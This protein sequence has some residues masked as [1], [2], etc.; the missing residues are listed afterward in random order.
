MIRAWIGS[1][2]DTRRFCPADDADYD[3]HHNIS[4][5][6][7]DE[8]RESLLPLNEKSGFLRFTQQGQGSAQ[9]NASQQGGGARGGG[10]D[11][12]GG[13]MV[14]D[15]VLFTKMAARIHKMHGAH[16]FKM[17]HMG[18]ERCVYMYAMMG[19]I[20]KFSPDFRGLGSHKAFHYEKHMRKM[21]FSGFLPGIKDYLEEE[22]PPFA[23]QVF[24]KERDQV[25]SVA[26]GVNPWTLLSIVSLAGQ[27]LLHPTVSDEMA[28]GIVTQILAK[29]PPGSTPGNICPTRFFNSNT[30]P[31]R[32]YIPDEERPNHLLRPDDP[33]FPTTG[34]LSL[35]KGVDQFLPEDLFPC[36]AVPMIAKTLGCRIDQVPASAM[37]VLQGCCYIA[38]GRSL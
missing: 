29:A 21:G 7:T 27:V 12:T 26:M 33:L 31:V 6:V 17:C 36:A 9:A 30:K 2:I 38:G 18:P 11:K 24:F 16:L 4:C 23:R 35:A 37:K 1:C 10:H 14:E 25:K 19:L 3:V 15:S 28:N 22:A 20:N 34:K 32:M 8:G 5:Y 13:S